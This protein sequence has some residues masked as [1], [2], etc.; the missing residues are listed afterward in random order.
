M[1]PSE[2]LLRIEA[3]YTRILGDKLAGIYVHGSLAFG[4]YNPAV[5]DIDFIAAVKSEPTLREKT[6]LV[7]VLLSLEAYYPEKGVEMSVVS[8]EVCRCFIHPAPYYLHYSNTYK[9]RA[10][11]DTEG[12]CREMHG[13]DR[14]LAAHFTVI[15]HA[16]YPLCG[17]PVKE[18]FGEVPYEAY[19]DSLM[20]DIE[21]AEADV[22]DAPV[23]VILNLCRVTAFL[24]CGEV[25]SKKAGGE[26]GLAH[27]PECR[28]GVIESAL[29]CYGGEACAIDGE[30]ARELA[31]YALER[32]REDMR[33]SCGNN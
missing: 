5:S 16:G 29:R 13:T 6:E 11:S 10:E 7:S 24:E 2:L 8:A 23:Y 19:V 9:D 17:V 30:A 15:R 12:F 3:E 1:T 4:C 31:R 22:A 18:M 14:D 21:N 32:I 26:W 25:I 28:H 20:Y 33:M 27:F